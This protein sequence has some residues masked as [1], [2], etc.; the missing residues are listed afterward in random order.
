MNIITHKQ[1]YRLKNKD[2]INK[3]QRERRKEIKENNIKFVPR[4]RAVEFLNK[5]FGRLIITEITKERDYYSNTIVKCICDCGNEKFCSFNVLKRGSIKSCG[6]LKKDQKSETYIIAKQ[7]TKLTCIKKGLW[8]D[9]KLRSAQL[10]Y[11]HLYS[12]GDI[13]FDEFLV[14][15]QQ[16]CFYCG[17]EPS[18][19]TTCY[20]TKTRGLTKER[21]DNSYFIYNGLDR[22]DNNLGHIKSNI[23]PCCKTCNYGKRIMSQ[24]EFF[25]WIKTI[26][27]KH[28]K[29]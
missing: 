8:K 22:I 27:N 29:N 1:A 5:R 10:T 4:V 7:K 21:F 19:R 16:N 23:V 20:S 13:S 11:K 14:L 3:R 18:N 28:F 25:E 17:K 24:N 9:P 26:Y 12:D 2:R 15:S 6:C